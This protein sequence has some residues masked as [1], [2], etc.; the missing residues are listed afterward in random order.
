MG[1]LAL[2]Y[3]HFHISNIPQHKFLMY[4]FI[5]SC[6]LLIRVDSFYFEEGVSDSSPMAGEE[7]AAKEHSTSHFMVDLCHYFPTVE[8]L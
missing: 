6:S 3:V 5:V 1:H 4:Q 8:V 2:L 7:T